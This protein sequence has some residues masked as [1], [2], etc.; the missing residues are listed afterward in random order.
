MA[1]S[2]TVCYVLHAMIHFW[3]VYEVPAFESG[4]ISPVR[5]RMSSG[6]PLSDSV[7]RSRQV[8]ATATAN[9]SSSTTNSIAVSSRIRSSSVQIF[10]SNAISSNTS[11]NSAG[12]L[13]DSSRRPR[14][15]SSNNGKLPPEFLAAVP[16]TPLAAAASNP[17][18]TQLL[19]QAFV[20]SQQ[21]QMARQRQLSNIHQFPL[22]KFPLQS[23]DI[24][25]LQPK[26]QRSYTDPSL[27]DFSAANTVLS[28]LSKFSPS[29]LPSTS[30]NR[31]KEKRKISS[32]EQRNDTGDSYFEEKNPDS[33]LSASALFFEETD[34]KFFV[35]SNTRPRKN[36]APTP[37]RQAADDTTATSNFKSDRLLRFYPQSNN[38]SSQFA[39]KEELSGI[40]SN[41]EAAQTNTPARRGRADSMSSNNSSGSQNKKKVSANIYETVEAR[42]LRLDRNFRIDQEELE[43]EQWGS[44]EIVDS[45]VYDLQSPG[46]QVSINDSG[47][48]NNCNI[49]TSAS[50]NDGDD[51]T[52]IFYDE[53]EA[54]SPKISSTASSASKD[55]KSTQFN[56]TAISEST[57]ER[58]RG[59]SASDAV[60]SPSNVR[61]KFSIFG[62]DLDE[63]D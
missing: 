15:N 39:R 29:Q 14:S 27:D 5:P 57:A 52:Y 36:S 53:D 13:G 20:Q 37:P 28:M 51:F 17:L 9:N 54:S 33:D 23:C 42:R 10:S 46:D 16:H 11:A 25:P 24:S 4:R 18:S 49:Q 22:N 34:K 50:S 58:K 2:A 40:C 32:D 1:L 6:P 35:L 38:R 7:D 44:E 21:Q 59:A 48:I 41:L 55:L 56:E 63:D 26:R 43:Q 45:I 47:L 60:P 8:A 3:N 62:N 12:T 31:E 61:R 30:E 19:Q